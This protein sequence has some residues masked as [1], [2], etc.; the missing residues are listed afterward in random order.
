[1]T[2]QE[3]SLASLG[4]VQF[5][6]SPSGFSQSILSTTLTSLFFLSYVSIC[7]YPSF[8]FPLR[9]LAVFPFLDN[10][11]RRHHFQLYLHF[12]LHF[13]SFSFSTVLL[14]R[15][16]RRRCVVVIVDAVVVVVV[17]VVVVVVVV[18]TATVTVTAITTV[19]AH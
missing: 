7:L 14:V 5:L 9:L 3:I 15:R 13:T 16:R 4:F 17:I 19:M 11:L 12:H 1:M 18:A 10:L 2:R 8:P 6:S